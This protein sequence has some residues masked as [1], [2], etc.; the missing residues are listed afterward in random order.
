[1]TSCHCPYDVTK[2]QTVHATITDDEKE[3]HTQIVA[4]LIVG[5]KRLGLP[6]E[7]LGTIRNE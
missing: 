1:M 2:K 3:W 6:D 5:T 7:E 4:F